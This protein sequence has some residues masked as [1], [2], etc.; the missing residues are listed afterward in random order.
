MKAKY[1]CNETIL[2]EEQ[3]AAFDEKYQLTSDAQK[4]YGQII[5]GIM[6]KMGIDAKKAEELTGLNG[7]LFNNL[8]KPDGAIL[9]RFVISIGVGFELDVHST[10]YILESCGMRFNVNDRLDKAYIHLLEEHK[11]KDIETCNAIL[12]DLGVEGKD[13]LG[14]LDRGSYVPRKKQ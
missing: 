8:K 10:E 6:A 3:K 7:N 14:E 9:K 13:M 11:G 4:T 1:I 2:T 5:L 12:R